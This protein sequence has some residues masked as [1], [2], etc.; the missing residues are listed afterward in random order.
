MYPSAS[1][2][3]KYQLCFEISGNSRRTVITA[4][5]SGTFIADLCTC[6]TETRIFLLQTKRYWHCSFMVF[7]GCK[8]IGTIPVF[9]NFLSGYNCFCAIPTKIPEAPGE[10][11]L[12]QKIISVSLMLQS[13]SSIFRQ[14]FSE[15]KS[16]C[17]SW[18]KPSPLRRY[19]R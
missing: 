8:T 19:H 10:T 14:L 3:R 17:R 16:L 18:K 15:P 13:R 1:R 9:L 12:C 7:F 5:V 11:G 6:V 4:P 2:F